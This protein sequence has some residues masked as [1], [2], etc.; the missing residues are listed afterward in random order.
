MLNRLITCLFTFCMA[1]SLSAQNVDAVDILDHAADAFR[2]AGGVE[3]DFSVSLPEAKYSGT[4]LLKGN[5]FVL[6]TGGITTWF[7][8]HTQ[9]TYIAE[10]DEVN[11]TTPTQEEL[12]GI[13]PYAWLSL[14]RHGYDL[15]LERQDSKAFH[16]LM[17]ASR[18]DLQLERVA[19]SIEKT[20][21]HP[22]ALSLTAKGSD[23]NEVV[24]TINAYRTGKNYADSMFVFNPK[25]YPT[26]EIIDMR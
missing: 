23:E 8:G 26:A 13:N 11:I 2:N 3:M 4:I 12:Q 21:F 20:S 25:E 22:L 6:K 10:N 16:I 24:I 5:M 1:L 9:W 17:T 19:L 14:Y 15:T 7:D 18:D